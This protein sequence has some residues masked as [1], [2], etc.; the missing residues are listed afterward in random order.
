M[1]GRQQNRSKGGDLVE[2]M[3]ILLTLCFTL[4]LLIPYLLSLYNEYRRR[5]A[6]ED[7]MNRLMREQMLMQANSLEAYRRML[8]AAFMEN[9][10]WENNDGEKNQD[11]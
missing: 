10:F 6:E 11:L 2:D 9:S 3:I 1:P 4:I 5:K 7:Q 8:H